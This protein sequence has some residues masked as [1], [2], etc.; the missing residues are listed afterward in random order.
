MDNI[1][2]IYTLITQAFDNV[3]KSFYRLNM[4]K[5]SEMI[6]RERV[7][8]Y[9]LYHQLRLLQTSETSWFD[10]HG[11]IDKRGFFDWDKTDWKNPDFIF[12]ISG[13]SKNLIV[14]EVKGE[15]EAGNYPACTVEDLR[16]L[17]MFLEH[18]YGQ[19]ILLVF[20]FNMSRFSEILLSKIRASD[21][22]G[23]SEDRLKA[24]SIVCKKD[25]NCKCEIRNLFDILQM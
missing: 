8:C 2:Q 5:T 10:I 1:N 15:I 3:P 11:E 18:G 4:A 22:N 9:E 16:K 21:I 19:G 14:V 24:I 13:E 6:T 12:H 7:F 17:L 20:N 25:Y 23:C